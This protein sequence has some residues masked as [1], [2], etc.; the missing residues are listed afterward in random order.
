[1]AAATKPPLKGCVAVIGDGQ[2]SLAVA[3]KH[4]AKST[5]RRF[6]RV[7]IISDLEVGAAEVV[8]CDA[9]VIDDP[10]LAELQRLSAPESAIG[11]I[12]DYGGR[13]VERQIKTR[14][15]TSDSYHGKS[16]GKVTIFADE[17]DQIWSNIA[18][19]FVS[20]VSD[21][22]DIRDSLRDLNDLLVLYTHG[23][24]IDAFLSRDLALCPISKS[25]LTLSH[26]RPPYCIEINFCHRQNLPLND[27]LVSR[28]AIHPLEIN[29]TIVVAAFCMGVLPESSY[30]NPRWGLLCSMLSSTAIRC[31]IVCDQIVQIPSEIVHKLCSDLR[32]GARVGAAVAACNNSILAKKNDVRF[33]LFGDP[34]LALEPSTGRM[35]SKLPVGAAAFRERLSG[36]IAFLQAYLGNAHK[37]STAESAPLIKNALYMLQRFAQDVLFGQDTETSASGSGPRMREAVLCVLSAR[38]AEISRDWRELVESSRSRYVDS[39]SA[40]GNEIISREFRMR[41]K[42]MPGRRHSRSMHCNVFEDV[43]MSSTL[44]FSIKENRVWLYGRPPT[45]AFMAVLRFSALGYQAGFC[46]KWPADTEGVPLDSIEVPDLLPDGPLVVSLFSIEGASLSVLSAPYRKGCRQYVL[47]PFGCPD[48]QQVL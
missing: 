45:K 41:D 31:I 30:V 17:V 2:R 11:L 1:M 47:C 42:R 33:T 38:G 3:A 14:A 37:N 10:L 32:G 22:E 21:S 36:D 26:D 15:Y 48:L 5:N 8:F 6:T 44:S 24:G 34:N 25:L 9:S 12:C 29:S 46:V 18:D 43:E 19:R 28:R 16:R 39:C 35:S 20:S 13:S 7:S 40:C 4:Y 23:D 27:M